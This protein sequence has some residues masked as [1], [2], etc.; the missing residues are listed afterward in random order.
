MTC[1]TIKDLILSAI[2]LPEKFKERYKQNV[3]QNDNSGRMLV[4][5]LV[6]SRRKAAAII[7]VNEETIQCSLSGTADSGVSCLDIR[8]YTGWCQYLG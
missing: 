3:C 4:G 5:K 8:T 6:W 2:L 7:L 1:L